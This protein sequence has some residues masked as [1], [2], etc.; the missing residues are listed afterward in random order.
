MPSTLLALLLLTATP[1]AVDT[2]VVCP[3]ELRAALQ[4]WI[5]LRE[6]QLHRL[7]VIDNSGTAEQLRARIRAAA[8]AESL[9]AILLVGDADPRMETDVR[10]RAR[11]VPTHL[12]PAKVNVL[13]GSEREIATDN[14]Y[15]DLDDDKIPD[16]AIGRLPADSPAELT[17]IVRKILM[18]EQAADAGSWRRRINFVAGISGVGHLADAALETATKSILCDHI[19]PAYVTSMTYASWRSP[20]CPAPPAFRAATV[21][22]L[23]EGCLFWVYIGHGQRQFL[24]AVMVP[25]GYHPILSCRDV[26]YLRSTSGLPIALFLACYTGA[27]DGE[28]DCLAEDMLRQPAGPVAVIAG[29]R[30]TMPYAMSVLGTEML[31]ECFDERQP[32]VGDVILQAKRNVMLKPREDSRSRLLDALASAFNPKGTSLI[33]E[34]EEH[35][36][37]FNLIGDPLL[38]LQHPERV[39]VMAAASAEAGSV[40]DVKGESPIDGEAEVELVVRRDRLTFKPTLRREYQSSPEAAEEY[41]QVY[42]KANDAR[43]ASKSVSVRQGKFAAQLLVPATA[44][45]ECHVRVFV[46]GERRCALGSGDLVIRPAAKPAA[47]TA[48][49]DRPPVR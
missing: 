1:P 16:V 27:F 47:T 40:L 22:R 45:G 10:I 49:R 44:N 34:R 13:W 24:D 33:D 32:T 28:Q 4:P 17:A 42:A 31:T 11:S 38:S 20:Y 37:L 8:S 15:A 19:P 21:E 46:Q 5:E 41:Q 48:G 6:G 9:K 26:P 2:V 18:Y 14:Y 35:N 3:A 25:E 36:Q 39:T 12:A 43:L 29:S 23:N 7:T 30:V